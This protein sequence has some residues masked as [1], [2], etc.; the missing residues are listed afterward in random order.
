MIAIDFYLIL[1][2][3]EVAI[4]LVEIQTL[5]LQGV[6]TFFLILHHNIEQPIKR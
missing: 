2:T 4:C 3:T 1:S 5:F 6:P